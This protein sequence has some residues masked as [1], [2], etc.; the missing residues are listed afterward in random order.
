[1]A[2]IEDQLREAFEEMRETARTQAARIAS[3]ESELAAR[4]APASP[5]SQ[6]GEDLKLGKPPTFD[7]AEQKWEDWDLK[8]KAWSSSVD[9][10]AGEDLARTRR[11][12]EAIDM[13]ELSGERRQ[14]SSRIYYAL[15]M[16]CDGGA[17]RIIKGVAR[18]NR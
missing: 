10:L 3:M 13:N 2:T 16:L 6:P 8:L 12:T 18:E 9:R 14:R 11:A 17:L 4:T 7:G 5:A 15:V 1:M